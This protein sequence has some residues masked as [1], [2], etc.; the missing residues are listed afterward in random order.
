MA[1]L[2]LQTILYFELK[3]H[4]LM[5]W[6]QMYFFSFFHLVGADIK[7]SYIP[8]KLTVTDSGKQRGRQRGPQM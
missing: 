6:Q 3:T 5:A 4:Y 8:L 1:A 7:M 2:N